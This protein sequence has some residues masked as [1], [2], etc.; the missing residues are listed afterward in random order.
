MDTRVTF[1]MKEIKRLYLMKKIV[2]KHMT[3]SQA[4]ELLR[5]SLR[6]IP[7]IVAIYQEKGAQGIIHGNR[8]KRTNNQIQQAVRDKILELVENQYRDYN[9]CPF[10][11][12][13]AETHGVHIFRSI[14]HRIHHQAN[15]KSP[16][17]RRPARHRSRWERK[18]L[19]DMLLQ[20]DGSL[21]DWLEGR[22][23]G[24]P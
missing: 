24:C 5:L 12:E 7:R 18:K 21:H 13:L 11:K 10:T 4:A 20:M 2:D 9:Y 19:A 23:R 22:G 6:Q 8:G 17:K 1:N 16:R 15:L 3:A 14:V